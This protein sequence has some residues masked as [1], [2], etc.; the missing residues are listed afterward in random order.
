MANL[1]FSGYLLSFDSICV[2][3]LLLEEAQL[4]FS[5]SLSR[6]EKLQF[7]NISTIILY[8][9]L[10][11]ILSELQSVNAVILSIAVPHHVVYSQLLHNQEVPLNQVYVYN[12]HKF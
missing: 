8:G 11:T 12:S 7:C 10:I 3:L 6:S 1:F 2:S 4:T 5:N 9:I